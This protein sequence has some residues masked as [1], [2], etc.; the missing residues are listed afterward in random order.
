MQYSEFLS[1][2]NRRKIYWAR[3]YVS[4]P[5]FSSF[6]PNLSHYILSDWEKRNKAYYH[7][8]QNVDSL[9]VKAGCLKLTELHGTSYKVSCLDC[10]FRLTREAM[11]VLIKSQN[12]QWTIMPQVLLN[13]ISP[14]ND[15]RLTDEQI[16]DFNTPKCPRCNNDRL[17]PEVGMS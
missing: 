13:D 5:L 12:P 11:Q 8:T 16:Q 2:S 10:D 17:K 4:W 1:S 7:V 14:D 6:K 15:V 3:N 9:L